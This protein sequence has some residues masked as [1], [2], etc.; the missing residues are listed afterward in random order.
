MNKFGKYLVKGM[1][2]VGNVNR[3]VGRGVTKG[4]DFV[5]DK[6][7]VPAAKSM[8]RDTTPGI[9][10]LW[11]GKRESGVGVMAAFGVAAAYGSYQGMKQTTLAPRTGQV[12]YGGTA[13][14]MNADGVSNTPQ[15]P[16]SGAPTLGANGQM[17]F[18]LH[19]AR[20]G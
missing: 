17:I 15:A 1:E 16:L 7:V 4:T 19:N 9:A 2:G 5:A 14:V 18:G 12:S 8:V 3:T 11:T 20:K 10:N 6:V 13:P